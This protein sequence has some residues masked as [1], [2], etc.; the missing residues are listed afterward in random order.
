MTAPYRYIRRRGTQW[1]GLLEG[2]AWG[3]AEA[4]PLPELPEVVPTAVALLMTQP[5]QQPQSEAVPAEM[6]PRGSSP[7]VQRI[8]RE[9][10][11]RKDP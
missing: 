3:L 7:P 4:L 2:V 10:A 5:V 9:T 1:D 11:P 6:D 8:L